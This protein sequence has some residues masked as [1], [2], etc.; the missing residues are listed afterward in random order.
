[1][2]HIV[3]PLYKGLGIIHLKP[4]FVKSFVYKNMPKKASD[5]FEKDLNLFIKP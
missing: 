2:P 3:K 1:M 4:W 5:F